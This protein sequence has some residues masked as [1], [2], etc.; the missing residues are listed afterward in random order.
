MLG[1]PRDEL[2]GAGADSLDWLVLDAAGDEPITVHPA[3]A[4]L[5]SRQRITGVL[6]RARR[7]AGPDLWLSVDAIPEP[8]G[9]AEVDHVVAL[10]TDVTY[11]MTRSRTS[12]RTAGDHIVDELTDTIA[13]ARM[14]PDVILTTV[15]NALARLRPGIWVASLIGKDPMKMQIFVADS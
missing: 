14:Q 5:K 12:R 15:T 10:L 6:C 11:L 1:M 7:A 3:V 4:A 9:S 2:I 13:H 8:A